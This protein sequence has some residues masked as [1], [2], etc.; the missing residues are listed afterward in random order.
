MPDPLAAADRRYRFTFDARFGF[1]PF[2]CAHCVLTAPAA[3]RDRLANYTNS[4]ELTGA[5]GMKSS[6]KCGKGAAA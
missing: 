5:N 4:H 2:A 6:T 3:E 1:D